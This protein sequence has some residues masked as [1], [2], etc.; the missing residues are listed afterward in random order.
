MTG[1]I[2]R[3]PTLRCALRGRSSISVVQFRNLK[4][5]SIPGRWKDS[6]LNEKLNV[7]SEG[8]F[9]ATNFGPSC[10]HKRGAQEWDLTLVG[11][12]K[13][14][15]G[16]GH[17]GGKEEMDEFECL[18][19]NITVPKSA[20]QGSKKKLPVF[21]WVH[22]GGL[23]MGSNSWPQYNIAKFVER[24]VEIGKPVVGVSINYR[25][26]VL[27]F[28]ASEEL[29]IDGNF[30]FKDQVLA[31]RWIKRHIAGFGGN[32][33]NVTAAAESAGGISLSVL[34][35]ANVGDD[36]L[37]DRV[38]I[39]SGEATLR[40]PRNRAWH[41][42]MYQDQLRM[43]GLERLG[44]DE[45][46]RKLRNIDTEE[47]MSKLPLAQH[48]CACV[49]GTFLAEDV[50]LGTMSDGRHKQH[51][52]IWC[53]EFVIGDTAHDGTVLKGRIL[54]NP[55]ALT[56]LQSL[57]AKHLTT[58]EASALLTAYNLHTPP[59][60]KQK[61]RLLVLAS[62][63][64]FYLP[65]IAAYSGWKSSTP[66]RACRRY[67]FHVPNPIEGPFLGLASHEFDIA[68]LL[69]NFE[70]HMDEKTKKAAIDMEDQWIRFANNEEWSKEDE[71]V[72]IGSEGVEVVDEKEY[73]LKFR[74]GRGEIL[75]SIEADKLWKIADA[76]Q[77]VRSEERLETGKA[78]M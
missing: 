49:D 51:K 76:W 12:V 34:L 18:T 48:F 1:D 70:R 8:L 38:V 43:L 13:M 19:V 33:S 78:K 30:G 15:L 41:E 64:R 59:T 6:I 11:D 22:G 5:A 65:T 37:F 21:V 29:G 44:V 17:A 9:N 66:S 54:D 27:G 61:H 74:D 69:R 14:P 26:G 20:I 52:P 71:L 35:C 50:R 28:L 10:P 46:R 57:C 60:E 31:F 56:L 62:E 77:G 7:D 58:S 45:R 36:G 4:Y 63:L 2:L 25:T 67:H 47:L 73:D 53:K 68:C 3:H 75:K 32:P 72:V 16:E 42:Q 24:S 39:M 55:N 40:K 23:S